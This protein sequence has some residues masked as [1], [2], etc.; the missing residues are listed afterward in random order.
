MAN[1][2]LFLIKSLES[3]KCLFE[4][5]LFNKA[6]IDDKIVMIAVP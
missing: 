3:S 4:D 1:N 5:W 6:V 2:I